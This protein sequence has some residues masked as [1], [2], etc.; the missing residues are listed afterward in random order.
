MGY[1]LV[2]EE[3]TFKAQHQLQLPD[4]SWEE[5]HEHEWLLRVYVRTQ[6]L[7][8]ENLVVDFLDLQA[9][10]KE[11]LEP[12]H[13][14]NINTLPPYCDGVNPSAEYIAYMFYKALA[15]RIDNERVTLCKVELR[16]APTSWGI[17]SVD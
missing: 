1:F 10:F 2:M 13:G 8:N 14:Q 3:Q 11:V 12:F 9:Y 16:E 17:Y 6:T 7:D 4:G 15:P 5:L